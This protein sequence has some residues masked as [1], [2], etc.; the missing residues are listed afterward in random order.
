M[1]AHR[2]TGRQLQACLGVGDGLSGDCL[3]VAPIDRQE[4]RGVA[5]SWAAW[6]ESPE[7]F[8][9]IGHD[10]QSEVKHLR[11]PREDAPGPPT[12]RPGTY[13]ESRGGGKKWLGVKCRYYQKLAQLVRLEDAGGRARTDKPLRATD[14]KSVAYTISPRR[15]AGMRGWIRRGAAGCQ[16]FYGA[17]GG[18]LERA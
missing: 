6:G 5:M 2:G 15:R 13:L 8:E 1:D 17:R 14:F 10:D 9:P 7:D 4:A 11:R 3:R 16:R 18:L 12:L